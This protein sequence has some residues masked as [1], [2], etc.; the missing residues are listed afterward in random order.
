MLDSH[1][2]HRRAQRDLD[3]TQWE[4]ARL[5]RRVLWLRVKTHNRLHEIWIKKLNK[6]IVR[7]RRCVF[8]RSG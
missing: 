8:P 4:E 6:R 2:T 5:N 1:D 3:V 7:G